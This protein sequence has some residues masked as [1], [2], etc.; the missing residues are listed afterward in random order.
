MAMV[1]KPLDLDCHSVPGTLSQ[2]E[3]EETT[4]GPPDD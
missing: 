4:G 1:C 3:T 2:K